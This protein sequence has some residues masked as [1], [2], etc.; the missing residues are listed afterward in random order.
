MRQHASEVS[1]LRAT[2]ASVRAEYDSLCKAGERKI[3][4]VETTA[5]V[6]DDVFVFIH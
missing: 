5:K 2:L 3:K 1:E 6:R 4:E